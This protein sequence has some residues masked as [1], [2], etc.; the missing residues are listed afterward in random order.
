[1]RTRI[2]KIAATA[3]TGFYVLGLTGLSYGQGCSDA[4]FCTMGAMKPNQH[5]PRKV[6]A[7]V[8]SVEASQYAGYTKFHTVILTYFVDVNASLGSKT[9]LQLKL[10]YTLVFGALAN[11]KG[12]G[13]ISLSATRNLVN[14]ENY[15]V[16]F[17]LGAKLPTNN[18]NIKT[19]GG[20][21]L[22]MYYQTSLGTYDMVL[23]ASLISKKWLFAAGYQQA[24][25]T[26]GNQFK[27]G[28]WSDSPDFG[29]AGTYPIS[30]HLRRGNDIM[31]R[32]ER[33]FRSA[34]FNTYL[35]LLPIYRLN[36]DI[37]T[38]PQ[39]GDRVKVPGSDGLTLNLLYGFGYRFSTRSAFKFVAGVALIKRAINPDGLSREVVNSISYE[40]RF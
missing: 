35:G 31:F 7:R 5:F 9:G 28:A 20:R 34:R 36:K 39:T 30:Q 13:D 18:A 19:S 40:L 10:P 4:G 2:F 6:N 33:N 21:P 15:Q 38:S 14:K 17:T 22:P 37:I 23:G 3:L 11:T 26:N 8:F 1:M 12:S 16:N 24:F 27:W 29:E 25:N 32:V